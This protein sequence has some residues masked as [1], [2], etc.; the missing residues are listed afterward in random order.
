MV[1][2]G[3]LLECLDSE[4]ISKVTVVGRSTLGM[5]HQKLQELLLPDL[6]QVGSLATQMGK[7]DGCFHCMGVSAVGLSENE[8]ATLTFD[9]TK[10]LADTCHT[11]NPQMVFNYVSGT[12]TDSTENGGSMWARVK[13]KTENYVLQKGFR[14]AFMFR[15]GLIIPEKG[16]SSKTGW[17]SF[18]YTI[19]R[20][21]FPLFKKS[22]NVTTTTK[23]GVAMINTL[24]T[25]P[26]KLHLE[27]KDINLLA[28]ANQ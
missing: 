15:P 23:L 17:Y 6:L 27:N 11:I 9:I 28:A 13:G 25:T 4:A 3:V 21:F 20:P 8:Y 7:P 10:A 14:A 1:G 19:M 24:F 26:Q 16:I 12:G 5:Q 22:K 18:F 2:K